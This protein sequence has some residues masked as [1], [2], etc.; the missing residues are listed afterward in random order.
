MVFGAVHEFYNTDD[1][2]NKWELLYNATLDILDKSIPIRSFTFPKSKPE[3]MVGEL[4]EFMKDRDSALR[5]ATRTKDPKDKKAARLARNKVNTLIQIAKNNFIKGKLENF[6]DK[7]KKFWEQIKSVMPTS[8]FL[9]AI[10]LENNLGQKLNNKEAADKVNTY[11]TNKLL[12]EEGLVLSNDDT[13]KYINN[14]FSTIGEV[15]A[16][17]ISDPPREIID[18]I[19]QSCQVNNMN[20]ENLE[21][22]CYIS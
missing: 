19:T 17:T 12:N 8:D 4:V 20:V 5:K 18:R 11:F 1:A 9:N 6:R 10:F 21:L 15:L 7:P 22:D 14:Y 16:K 3:W 13:P 2:D